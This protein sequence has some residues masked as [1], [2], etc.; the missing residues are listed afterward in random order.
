[1][2]KLL[3]ELFSLVSNGGK[4]EKVYSSGAKFSFSDG[5]RVLI[6]FML[7][8]FVNLE[9]LAFDGIALVHFDLSDLPCVLYRSAYSDPGS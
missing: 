9:S 6:G 1:M 4:I 7:G 2:A 8:F 3:R 5:H